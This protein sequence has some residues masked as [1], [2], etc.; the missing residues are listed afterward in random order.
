MTYSPGFRGS[1][2]KATKQVQNNYTNASGFTITK[3]K[4]VATNSSGNIVLLNPADEDLVSAIVGVTSESIINLSSGAVISSGKLEEL[5]TSFNVGDAVY[6]GIN[7]EL[8]NHK[9]NIGENGFEVGYF[10]VF[11]GV[12][13]KNEFD[14]LKKDLLVMPSLVGQL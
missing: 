12:I 3:G 7:G 11:I 2:G 9:P 1:V 8:I 5:T 14:P 4:V 13:V 10:V 6:A